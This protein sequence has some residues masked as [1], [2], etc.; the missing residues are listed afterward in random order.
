MFYDLGSSGGCRPFLALKLLQ[1]WGVLCAVMADEMSPHGGLL[2]LALHSGGFDSQMNNECDDIL[3][4]KAE[5]LTVI[6]GLTGTNT[7]SFG[8][9]VKKVFSISSIAQFVPVFQSP[10]K[11]D[12]GCWC[13]SVLNQY[14][15]WVNNV[16][17]LWIKLKVVLSLINNSLNA[18]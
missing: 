5:N 12:S 11:N 18:N 17:H 1:G 16:S 15:V 6:C 8:G 9:T 10:K 3:W 2:P 13:L 7:K 4:E 14:D